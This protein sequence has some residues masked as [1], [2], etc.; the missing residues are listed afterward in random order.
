MKQIAKVAIQS[1]LPQLDRLF[2]YEIP[3]SLT[4]KTQIGSKVKVSFGRSAKPLEAFIVD[5]VGESNFSGKLSPIID[6][7]GEA[8]FL[9]SDIL[10]VAKELSLRYSCNLGEI[11]KVAVPAHMPRVYQNWL[12]EADKQQLSASP[13]NAHAK[14]QRPNPKGQKG[15][16]LVRPLV[17]Y[18]EVTKS[19]V[20]SWVQITLSTVTSVLAEGRSSI[21]LLP[22]YREIEVFLRA[23]A[24]AGLADSIVNYSP[25]QP[26]SKQYEAFLRCLN[27]RAVVVVGTR[28]A[29]FAP[30]RS[31]G[32]II[33]FDDAD[34]SFTDQTSPYLLT[35]DVVLIRQS[36]SGCDVRFLSHSVTTDN[37]RLIQSGFLTDTSEEFPLPKVSTSEP[38]LRVDSLGYKAIK[39]GLEFGSVLVQVSSRGDTTYLI[40]SACDSPARCSSCHGSLWKD[41]GGN[42]KCRLCNAFA[43]DHRC[44]CGSTVF[45]LGRAG[46]TRTAAELGK[47]FPT[48]RVIESTGEKQLTAIG[49]GRCLVVA[50]VGA[51]P[52][53]EE[54]YSAV[55]ILDAK[56]LLNRPKLRATEDALRVWSNAIAKGSANAK[57]VVVGIEGELAKNFA[58]W[59]HRK[60]ASQ[61]LQQRVGLKLPP[62]V[63]LGSISGEKDLV[64]KAAVALFG[65]PSIEVI[66]P[67]PIS[68]SNLWRILFKYSHAAVKD[69]GRFLKAEIAKI[70]LGQSRVRSSGRVG[71]ALVV[72]MNDPEVV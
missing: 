71:R 9:S 5:I 17:S 67:A 4:P 7:V 61:E 60:L 48:A 21:V 47:M 53:A 43:L 63:R 42:L 59:D 16:T 32:E 50:T 23:S 28:Q 37:E 22:D 49:K 25:D 12:S 33:M 65:M 46:A 13:N 14:Q 10:E 8:P 72:K 15:F 1:S 45:S 18:S 34:Q 52:Y 57:A 26:K 3:D 20:P 58:L 41:S 31:L 56:V 66:G 11:L 24:E 6:V 40:C 27:D 69:V 54:G 70:S 62:V 39:S 29:A 19:F 30:V 68:D 38:G 64:S 55:V 44:S 36:I 35:K 2:D 51:E